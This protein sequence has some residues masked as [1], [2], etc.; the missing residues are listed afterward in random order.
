[1]KRWFIIGGSLI[2][3]ALVVLAWYSHVLGAA[4]SSSTGQDRVIEIRE[5]ETLGEI[6]SDLKSQSVIRST[7]AFSIHVRLNGLAPKFK[8][9]P[10]AVSCAQRAPVI[11]QTMTRQPE[12]RFFTIKEGW[13]LDQVAST[14][15]DKGIVDEG[16]FKSL[17]AKDFPEY[18]FLKDAPRDATL[19]GFLYPETYTVPKAGTSESDVARIMLDE[20]K[21]M[22]ETKLNE[23]QG[24][25]DRPV[26]N[27][28]E[29]VIVASMI[30]E[31]V[32][33]EADRALVGGIIYNRLNQGIRLDI[34][35]TT[36]YALGKPTASLTVDDL[37]SNNPYNTRKV[38]GLPPGPIANPSLSALLAALNPKASEYLFYLS[39]RDGKTYFA[40]TNAEHEENIANHLR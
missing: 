27:F 7:T 8:S 34:D 38:K 37:N 13:T 24:A 1:M 29:T 28:Y 33:S 6:T 14:L 31:E 40:K 12:Q 17:K 5:N 35:A 10:H 21:Q 11:A 20:F 4:C 22:Y 3:A 30:E 32:R 23:G 25:A 18:A 9:G 2:A 36:R 16:K 19:E 39:G 15:A 26:K